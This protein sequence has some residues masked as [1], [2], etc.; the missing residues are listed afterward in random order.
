MHGGI[1][2]VAMLSTRIVFKSQQFKL[3]KSACRYANVM[4]KRSPWLP[5]RRAFWCSSNAKRKIG[6][7]LTRRSKFLWTWSCSAC[8]FFAHPCH[9]LDMHHTTT[10]YTAHSNCSFR[11]SSASLVVSVSPFSCSLLTCSP[12]CQAALSLHSCLA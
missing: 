5:K 10:H 9:L 11:Y 4:P 6:A 3:S 8:S 1:L 2:D 7:F 12:C